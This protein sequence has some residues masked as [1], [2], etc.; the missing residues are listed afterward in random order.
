MTKKHFKPFR[1]AIIKEGGGGG[2]QGP[3]D[4]DFL[5]VDQNVNPDISKYIR[6]YEK[7]SEYI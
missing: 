3:P 1:D 2:S 7:I 4:P 5:H 6:L